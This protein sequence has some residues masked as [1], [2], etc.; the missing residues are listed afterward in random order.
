M[1]Y[2]EKSRYLALLLFSN[3]DTQVINGTVFYYL[4]VEFHM[5]WFKER[6]FGMK[7]TIIHKRKTPKAKLRE[8]QKLILKDMLWEKR[9]KEKI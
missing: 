2:E 6:G 3:P 5:L 9:W 8:L 7:K 4:P 1:N